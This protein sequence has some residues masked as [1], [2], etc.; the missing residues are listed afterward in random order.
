[1]R[2]ARPPQFKID[3][4]ARKVVLKALAERYLPRDNRPPP[5]AG[6]HDAARSLA[7]PANCKDDIAEALGP[8]GI[9]RRGLLRPA[10]IARLLAEHTSGRK[11]HAMRLWVLLILERWFARYAPEFAL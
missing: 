4:S 3:G 5:Q 11:N 8:R 9:A 2:A 1:M 7:R 6:V 10:T